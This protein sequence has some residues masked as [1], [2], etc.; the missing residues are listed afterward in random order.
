[1]LRALL[2]EA[3]RL[4]DAGQL[5]SDWVD[6]V[7]RCDKWRY[8][9]HPVAWEMIEDF[10]LQDLAGPGDSDADQGGLESGD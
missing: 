7:E 9:T 1:M 10:A 5:P 3:G 6:A 4:R 8:S 2:R